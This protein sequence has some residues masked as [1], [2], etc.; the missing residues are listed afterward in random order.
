[1][2]KAPTLSKGRKKWSIRYRTDL[3][4][5]LLQLSRLSW[6]RENSRGD[7]ALVRGGRGVVRLKPR[8]S[9]NGAGFHLAETV[10]GDY[11]RKGK[12]KRIEERASFRPGGYLNGAQGF[13]FQEMTS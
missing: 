11:A 10:E 3:S 8:R 9:R 6:G 2:E 13:H 4:R 12:L 1:M 5:K 7:K